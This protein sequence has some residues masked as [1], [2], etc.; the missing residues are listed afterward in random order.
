MSEQMLLKDV[1][2]KCA[3][4]KKN[5]EFKAWY[6]GKGEIVVRVKFEDKRKY[7]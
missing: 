3:K 6:I 4:E 7:R 2:K 5:A 1:E